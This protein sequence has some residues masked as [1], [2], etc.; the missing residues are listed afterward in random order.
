MKTALVLSGG[1]MFG[2]WQAGAWSA[3]A[4]AFQPDLVVGASVGSLNGYAIAAGWDPQELCDFWRHPLVAGGFRRLPEMIQALMAARPLQIE[5]ATVLVDPLRMKPRTFSGPEITWR[6]LAASCAVPGMLPPQRI[7]G[8]WHLDGGLLNPLPVWAAV[9]LGATRII[10]LQA[11]PEIPSPLL[12][13]FVRA[14]RAVFGHQPKLQSGVELITLE[15]SRRLGSLFDA[16][17][18]KRENIDRWLDQG[19][20][21]V[22][23][24]KK[25]LQPQMF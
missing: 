13:P 19:R 9:E 4:P 16:L 20:T 10:A 24:A 7:G 15:P 25:H 8:R 1:G 22:L 11:L 5:Y 2:A 3:L 6:H 23:A 18:W 14:F 12:K 17:Y 21:D